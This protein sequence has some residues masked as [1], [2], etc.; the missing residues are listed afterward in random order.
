MDEPTLQAVELP[1]DDGRLSFLVILPAEGRF[2]EVGRKLT[3]ERL[4]EILAAM[5]SR[6]GHPRAS[7]VHLLLLLGLGGVLQDLGLR[8]PS[9]GMPTSVG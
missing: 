3:A 7:P 9:R 4:D 1:Y 2:A 6:T 5:G 8:P